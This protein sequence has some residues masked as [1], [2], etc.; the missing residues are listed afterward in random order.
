MNWIRFK[1]VEHTG[2]RVLVWETSKRVG[3]R[4][5]VPWD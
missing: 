4:R 2:L 3:L 1:E 5:V